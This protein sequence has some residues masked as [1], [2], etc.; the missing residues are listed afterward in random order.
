[1][2]ASSGADR[3]PRRRI[4][5]CGMSG[6]WRRVRVQRIERLGDRGKERTRRRVSCGWQNQR[7]AV[8]VSPVVL[9]RGPLC[10][11]WFKLSFFCCNPCRNHP[12]SIMRF[13]EASTQNFFPS[14]ITVVALYSVITAG[15]LIDRPGTRSPRSNTDVVTALS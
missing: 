13:S 15:P 9:S 10:P 2:Q 11:L 3:L 12:I 6:M 5:I 8:K 1:M 14:G 4:R 7:V